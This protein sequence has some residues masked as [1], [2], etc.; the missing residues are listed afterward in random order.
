MGA[1]QLVVIAFLLLPVASPLYILGSRDAMLMR[2]GRTVIPVLSGALLVYAFV[3]SYPREV[4]ILG[5]VDTGRMF[6]FLSLRLD[7]FNTFVYILTCVFFAFNFYNMTDSDLPAR[8]YR[9]LACVIFCFSLLLG[10]LFYIVVAW[11]V[12]FG[13]ARQSKDFSLLEFL[14]ELLLLV[15]ASYIYT[16]AGTDQFNAVPVHNFSLFPALLFSAYVVWRGLLFPMW[17]WTNSDRNDLLLIGMSMVS[18]LFALGTGLHLGGGVFYTETFGDI[19]ALFL[20]VVAFGYLTYRSI[21]K[22]ATINDMLISVL[23]TGYAFFYTGQIPME[24]A[25]LSVSICVLF[26]LVVLYEDSINLVSQIIVLIAL[27]GLFPLG[28]SWSRYIAFAYLVGS[29]NLMFIFTGAVAM[30]TYLYIL[31]LSVAYKTWSEIRKPSKQVLVVAVLLAVLSVVPSLSWQYIF[32]SAVSSLLFFARTLVGSNLQFLY[33]VAHEIEMNL[34]FALA[35]IIWLLVLRLVPSPNLSYRDKSKR[36]VRWLANA[37]SEISRLQSY[38]SNR[39]M[40]VP[41]TAAMLSVRVFSSWLWAIAC[42]VVA[43][44]AAKLLAR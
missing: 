43:I 25:G 19:L 3:P 10:G 15:A 12:A 2:L 16:Q 4:V 18:A 37:K 14:P 6:L 36:S 39:L 29:H 5:P 32:F 35:T 33:D 13:L 9:F 40:T 26:V 31:Y 30:L 34:P 38:I 20:T 27:T 23:A 7:G 22:S 41:S 21:F 17:F 8:V 24:V 28:V 44:L 11:I 42:L 1:Q